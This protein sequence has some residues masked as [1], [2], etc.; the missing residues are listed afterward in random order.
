MPYCTHGING[1]LKLTSHWMLETE[2]LTSDF[3][4]TGQQI[5][6]DAKLS[7]TTEESVYNNLYTGWGIESCSCDSL[8]W[9]MQVQQTMC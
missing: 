6:P 9:K 2:C 3:G 4:T 8:L 5:C 1:S 7:A